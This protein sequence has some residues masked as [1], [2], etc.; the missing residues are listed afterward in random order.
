ML[1]EVS[2]REKQVLVSIVIPAY[3]VEKYIKRCLES[4]LGQSYKNLQ[5]IVI[6][7]ASPDKTGEICDQIASKDSRI[8]V[9]HHSTN[10][11]VSAARNSGIQVARGEYIA[12]VDGDDFIDRS[13]IERCI[14]NIHSSDVVIF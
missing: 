7:D 6:D 14:I 12:F 13:L 8:Q 2:M 5:I 1:K 4:I 3:K 11:G 10:R 9:I